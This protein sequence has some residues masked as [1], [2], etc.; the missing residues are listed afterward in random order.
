MQILAKQIDSFIGRL[1]VVE[2]KQIEQEEAV[3][4]L[5]NI[6]DQQKTLIEQLQSKTSANKACS[7]MYRYFKSDASAEHF[8]QEA[9]KYQQ[10]HGIDDPQASE[11]L[12]EY[13]LYLQAKQKCDSLSQ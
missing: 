2:T 3:Q 7:D 12:N 4:G 6:I 1:E 10:V 8:H 9:L 5:Q 11:W 13:Q